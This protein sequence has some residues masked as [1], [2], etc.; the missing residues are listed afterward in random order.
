MDYT[1]LDVKKGSQT[2]N[3]PKYLLTTSFSYAVSLSLQYLNGVHASPPS[4]GEDCSTCLKWI[5]GLVV[6]FICRPMG[7]RAD[8]SE[9]GGFSEIVR[10]WTPLNLDS[11]PDISRIAANK[12]FNVAIGCSRLSLNS[13]HYLFVTSFSLHG[14]MCAKRNQRNADRGEVDGD[15]RRWS[16]GHSHYHS[17]SDQHSGGPLEIQWDA[18]NRWWS[19]PFYKRLSN[20][21]INATTNDVI[22]PSSSFSH[23][24]DFSSGV[25]FWSCPSPTTFVARRL[26]H[27]CN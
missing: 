26:L 9:A 25:S 14:G 16:S 7:K 3:I 5:Y 6:R 1:S 11:V 27:S 21:Q 8:D 4:F 13:R 17:E 12:N 2:W 19:C 15:H 10:L 24:G 23:Q 18:Q 20:V 22:G